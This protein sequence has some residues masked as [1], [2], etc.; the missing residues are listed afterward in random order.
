MAASDQYRRQRGVVLI[1]ALL[2]VALVTTIVVSVSWRFN[3]SMARNENRWH[4]SQA[5][6]YLD[7]GE[8]L[9]RLV[10]RED[11]Q[12][13]LTDHLAE[14]WAQQGDP[15]PTDEGW[16]R[17][18]IEDAHGRLNLNLMVQQFR[19]TQDPNLDMNDPTV[20]FTAAQRRLIRLL[21]TFELENGP[22]DV[23]EATSIV[24]ALQD[25]LDSDHE[26][27]GMGGAEQDY[28]S[29]A[30]I[31][32]PV[33]NGPIASVSDLMVIRGMTPEIYRALEPYVIALDT[34]VTL[35]INTMPPALFRTFNVKANLEPLE[36]GQANA[37]LQIRNATMMT[38]ENG[39]PLKGGF[40]NPDEFGNDPTV[41][42]I[43]G[44]KDESETSDLVVASN[45]F[46]YFGETLVGE[47]VRRS[48]AVLLRN[49]ADVSVLR[50][51]D[52][53]F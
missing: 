36:E 33:P 27:S 13:G 43:I 40:Q 21:Q 15:L 31:E 32:Y 42:S 28:Y 25:W 7:G 30:G 37:L 49:G 4:G 19:G 2:I 24:E 14:I 52:A 46:L 39:V 51:T 18:R 3:L 45:Y 6:A 22:M 47:Q 20:R 5:R 29:G 17:G 44:S 26:I 34:S 11:S 10:L 23:N 35:N 9:A 41:Q 53:G 8:Q 38:D 12:Q 50:R 1:M 16:I 48:K